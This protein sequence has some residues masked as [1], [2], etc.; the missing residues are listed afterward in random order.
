[1]VRKKAAEKLGDKTVSGMEEITQTGG[2][3]ATGLANWILDHPG[4]SMVYA[5]VGIVIIANREH[6]IDAYNFYKE[7]AL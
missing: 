7:H 5:A 2:N 3:P 6:N 1:M 4:S